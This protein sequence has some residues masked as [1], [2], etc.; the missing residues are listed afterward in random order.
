MSRRCERPGCSAPATLAYG[1]S[2]DRLLAWLAPLA[3]GDRNAGGALCGRHADAMVPPRGWWLDDRRTDEPTLFRSPE[4]RPAGDPTDRRGARG[5]DGR[6]RASRRSHELVVGEQL[7]LDA[8][9]VG[10]PLV[11]D[12]PASADQPEPTPT[13]AP[14]EPSLPPAAP[15]TPT[16]DVTDDLGGLLDASTPLLARA[17][18]RRPRSTTPPAVRD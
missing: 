14:D 16:F 17:F 6:R 1:F 12:A 8:E 13:P 7:A 18:G 5:D 11:D 3:V 10:E 15:W 9:V 4:H 2:T